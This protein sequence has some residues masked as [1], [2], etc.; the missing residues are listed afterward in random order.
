MPEAQTSKTN[1]ST[2]TPPPAPTNEQLQAEIVRMRSRLDQVEA[3]NKALREQPATE[4]PMFSIQTEFT[5]D[6]VKKPLDEPLVVVTIGNM[7]PVKHTA[8][9]WLL[10]CEHGQELVAYINA[11]KAEA[12]LK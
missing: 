4:R 1:G 9:K 5:K 8:K 2:Q 10:L 7:F 6:G 11:H 12:G 3:E